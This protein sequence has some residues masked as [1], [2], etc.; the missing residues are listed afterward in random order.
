[1]N[2]SRSGGNSTTEGWPLLA[3][4]PG[5]RRLRSDARRNREQILHAALAELT[6][7]TPGKPV[8]LEAVAARA[9]VG[10]GTLYRRFP[11]REALVEAVYLDELE[12][13]CASAEQLLHD[14]PP[15]Q[16]LRAWM[17]R[18]ADFVATKHG[19]ADALRGL[20]ASGSIT[21]T[22]TRRRLAAAA[23]QMLDAGHEAELLRADVTPDDVV[24]AMA[25]AL[26]A[27]SGEQ[28]RDQVD[29]LLDLLLDGLR[30]PHAV[31]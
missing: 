12:R 7:G 22:S 19:M 15:D 4:E 3:Q 17:G 16:A 27:A 26:L 30:P 25:G 13:L 20:I 28:P 9:G 29:R 2:R 11:T 31:P 23:G 8:S 5:G 6:E 1:M 10:V 18:Y 21:S 14:A 24:A